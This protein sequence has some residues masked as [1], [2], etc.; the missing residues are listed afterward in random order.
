MHKLR[1]VKR[2]LKEFITSYRMV[3]R[4]TPPIAVDLHPCVDGS[5]RTAQVA[6]HA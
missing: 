1:G 3:R 2:L 4:Y 5:A 6:L